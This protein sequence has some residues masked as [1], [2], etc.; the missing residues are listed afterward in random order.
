MTAEVKPYRT[1]ART[2]LIAL[3]MGLTSAHACAASYTVTDLGTLG[4]DSYAQAINSF[5]QVAGWYYTRKTR[6]KNGQVVGTD[7]HA[8]I[9]QNGIMTDLGDLPGSNDFSKAYGI[10]ASGQVVG[11]S[12]TSS[13][14]GDP[15]TFLWQNGTM[16]D[17]GTLSGSNGYSYGQ[18]IN[19][20]GQVVGSSNTPWSDNTGSVS[21]A[22]L[23]DNG[24]FVDLGALQ[25]S[26]VRAMSSY[27]QAINSS[28]QV[29]GSSWIDGNAHHH[30]F[31]FSNGTMTDLGRLPGGTE[32]YGYAINDSGQ[33]TGKSSGHAFLWQNGTMTDLGT[34]GGYESIGYGINATGQ[35]VGT[36]YMSGYAGQSA[37]IYNNGVM[38]N[39]NELIDPASGWNLN[40]ANAINDVGQIVGW[41]WRTYLGETHGFLLTP[42]PEPHIFALMLAGLGFVGAVGHRHRRR[43][44]MRHA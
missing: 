9:W 11:Y 21:H 4:Y 26:V 38:T 13:G 37:F 23:Y 2:A 42:V 35:V 6:L 7:P 3:F 10:N 41:G 44:D 30:A 25:G 12:Y 36:S 1:M 29:T 31:L 16:T 28:G 34:L 39:L 17:L 24:K 22:F 5:G 18:G 15:H 14:G 20:S 32:S 43:M 8:F 19:S 40:E 27:G 33:V